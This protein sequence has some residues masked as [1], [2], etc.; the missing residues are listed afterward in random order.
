MANRT[1]GRAAL[2]VLAAILL[3]SLLGPVFAHLDGVSQDRMHPLAAPGAG[4]WLGTDAFG[5]DQLARLLLGTRTSLL[6]G[7]FATLLALGGGMVLGGLAGFYPGWRDSLVMRLAE[8]VQSLPWFFLVLAVRALLPLSISPSTVLLLIALLAGATGWPRPCRLIRGIVLA[9][10]N[11]DYVLAAR[12]FGATDWYLLRR[13]VLP[14][15]WGTV[16]VQM[17][18]LIPQ[19]VMTEV[20]LSFLGLGTGEPAASLGT[21]LGGLRDVHVLTSCPW[22]LAPVA[23]LILLTFCCQT[24]ADTLR[25]SVFSFKFKP[26]GIN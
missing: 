12:A 18:I 17:V 8:L 10:R 22:M 15:A 14:A 23:I 24:T 20:T 6:A 5:R 16:A 4:H 21:M 3:V 11:R 1:W 13:H 19:F 25:G 26:Q 2:V 9:E 7:L